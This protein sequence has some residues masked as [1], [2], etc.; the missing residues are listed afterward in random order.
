MSRP[1][2]PTLV[3][4]KQTANLDASLQ[5]V[6]VFIN[7]PDSR[8]GPRQLANNTRLR[9][10]C[11]YRVYDDSLT[12][13]WIRDKTLILKHADCCNF[14]FQFV[15]TCCHEVLAGLCPLSLQSGF[16]NFLRLW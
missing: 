11:L 10:I 2:N 6:I 15:V 9:W 8:I 5:S 12:F 4:H 13:Y 7:S 14:F 1:T 3:Y 16:V